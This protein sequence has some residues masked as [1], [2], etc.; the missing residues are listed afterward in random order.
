MRNKILNT[1][2]LILILGLVIF[3]SKIQDLWYDIFPVGE[4]YG[5]K[6]NQE[7]QKR[8]IMVI[9]NNWG[10]KDSDNYTKTWIPDTNVGLR[11]RKI[12]VIDSERNE[13]V[14]EVDY[15]SKG[16]QNIEI[17]YSYEKE[18]TKES[19]WTIYYQQTGD[20]IANELIMKDQLDSMMIK[21]GIFPD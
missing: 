11:N 7:R 3:N 9:P 13:I 14:S 1:I 10:N 15:I 2:A 4:Q 5:V 20:S 6:W 12:V 16:D 8:G 17:I 21:W 19:P 18:N